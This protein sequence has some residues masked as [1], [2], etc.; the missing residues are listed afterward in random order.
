MHEFDRIV[1]RLS[2]VSADLDTIKDA[3]SIGPVEPPRLDPGVWKMTPTVRA[4]QEDAAD[5]R[6]SSALV[7]SAGDDDDAHDDVRDAGF[8]A[9]NPKPD[10]VGRPPRDV[11][12]ELV[13]R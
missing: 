10:R 4:E 7:Q 2:Q 9:A 6:D 3:A 13:T 11:L 12:T 1:N 8:S 5:R